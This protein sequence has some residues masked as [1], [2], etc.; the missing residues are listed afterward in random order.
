MVI[1]RPH[2]DRGGYFKKKGWWG[3]VDDDGADIPIPDEGWKLHIGGNEHNAP[4][5]VRA[6]APVLQ[7]S[8]IFHKIADSTAMIT[9]GG[10]TQAGKWFVAYPWSLAHAIRAVCAIDQIVGGRFPGQGHQEL[11]HT[12]PGDQ[13]VGQTVVYTRYGQFKRGDYI[14]GPNRGRAVVDDRS[15]PRP[16]HIQDLWPV[17]RG[18]LAGAPPPIDR[19][20]VYLR[21][22]FPVYTSV[23]RAAVDRTGGG[24]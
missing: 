23:E 16:D 3:W 18:L 1:Q 12:V 22:Q 9:Y 4:E 2:A 24:N 20:P 8:D 13:P 14:L 7:A 10:D 15:R 21:E 6:I 17:C 11:T 19:L 5:L